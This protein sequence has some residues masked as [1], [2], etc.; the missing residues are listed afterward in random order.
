[1]NALIQECEDELQSLRFFDTNSYERSVTLQAMKM[2]LE[3]LV[4]FAGRFAALADEMAANEKDPQ[5]KKELLEI[6]ETCR[7]VPANPAR[8]FKEAIQTVWFIFLVTSPSPTTAIGR[9]D[10][11]MY[12]LL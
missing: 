12:P 9:F 4:R 6:A 3:A 7:W 10:Q 11:Y 1:M 5:R 2:T 8:T